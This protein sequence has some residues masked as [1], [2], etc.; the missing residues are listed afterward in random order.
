MWDEPGKLLQPGDIVRLTKGYASIWRQSLT[1]YSGKNGELLKIGEFCMVFN[2]QL[3]MSE[4]NQNF[5]ALVASSTSVPPPVVP[6]GSVV[7]LNNGNGG[8]LSGPVTVP[9]GNSRGVVMQPGD[10]H[11]VMPQP[12]QR[13]SGPVPVTPPIP[14][15]V[16]IPV[17]VAPPVKPQPKTQGTRISRT[18]KQLNAKQERR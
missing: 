4:P 16:T 18:N 3:N 14:E 13:Y 8:P 11:K 15:T 2:E 12:S 6:G 1:L 5:G 17:T 7:G 9:V 10:T